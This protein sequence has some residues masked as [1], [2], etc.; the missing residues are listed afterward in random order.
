MYDKRYRDWR[1]NEITREI[2]REARVHAALQTRRSDPVNPTLSV[3]FK[4]RLWLTTMTATATG[5]IRHFSASASR[6]ARS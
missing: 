2:A 5:K 6:L 1:A 3:R 4:I